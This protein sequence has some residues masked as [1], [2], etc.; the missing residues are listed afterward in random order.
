ML[1]STDSYSVNTPLLTKGVRTIW[2]ADS[3]AINVTLIIAFHGGLALEEGL[4]GRAL[5]FTLSIPIPKALIK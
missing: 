3:D 2:P 4:R 5:R 1:H